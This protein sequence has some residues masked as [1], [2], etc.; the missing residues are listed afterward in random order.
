MLYF[1]D[2]AFSDLSLSRCLLLFILSSSKPSVLSILKFFH[3][4]HRNRISSGYE[5]RKKVISFYTFFSGNV[6]LTFLLYLKN[7]DGV[8]VCYAY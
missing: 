2:A 8:A 7:L 4:L 3:P 5:G 1:S 6:L